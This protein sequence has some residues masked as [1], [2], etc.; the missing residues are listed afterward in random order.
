MA[1]GRRGDDLR[2]GM[3]DLQGGSCAFY[4]ASIKVQHRITMRLPWGQD[5]QPGTY[6]G[7]RRIRWEAKTGSMTCTLSVTSG[8]LG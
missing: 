8:T 3:I 1:E 2:A 5:R 6:G 4:L 7:V